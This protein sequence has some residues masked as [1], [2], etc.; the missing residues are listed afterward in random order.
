VL[1]RHGLRP[2]R[3]WG[4][5]FLVNIDLAERI[6]DA[7]ASSGV[8]CAVEIGA[9]VGTLTTALAARLP[10]VVAVE[11]DPE[12]AALLRAERAALGDNVEVVMADAASFD[13]AAAVAPGPAAVVGNLPYNLT[14]RLLRRI[15]EARAAIRLALVMVQLEVA[16][17]LVAAPGSGGYGVLT[18]MCQAWLDAEILWRVSPGSFFPR[19]KVSSAVVRLLPQTTPRAGRIDEATLATVVHAAFASRRKTLRNAL[20][21]AFTREHALAALEAEGIDPGLRAETLPVE[22][23]AALARRLVS[24]PGGDPRP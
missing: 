3:S 12:L 11:R 21:A 20:G 23:L 1:R 9:G 16:E 6:A 15:I 7:V 18:V 19:P 17:R 8:V 10:R 24:G 2:K 22:Q 14:G 4:Q 13:Y 5:N